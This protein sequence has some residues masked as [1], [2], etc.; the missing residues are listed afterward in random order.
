[1]PPTLGTMK[2]AVKVTRT[3]IELDELRA[4]VRTFEQ[5]NPGTDASNYPDLFRDEHGTLIE[6]DK[7]DEIATMYDLLA[8]AEQGA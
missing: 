7:F 1:M 4:R 8:A 6:D 2:T 5:A 3:T